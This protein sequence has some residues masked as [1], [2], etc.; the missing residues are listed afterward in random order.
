[1]DPTDVGT[2]DDL[3]GCLDDLRQRRGPR[4]RQASSHRTREMPATTADM[5]HLRRVTVLGCW[6]RAVSR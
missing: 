2:P 6:R 3:A 5:P 1:M 4:L